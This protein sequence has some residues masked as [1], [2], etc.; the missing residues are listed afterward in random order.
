MINK[1]K[2]EKI[3]C[4]LD[5]YFKQNE[6]YQNWLKEQQQIEEFKKNHSPNVMKDFEDIKNGN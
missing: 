2:K 1:R 4:L 6:E 3:F 5:D